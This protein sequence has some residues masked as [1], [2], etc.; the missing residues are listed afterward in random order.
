MGWKPT[1]S[2]IDGLKDML[3]N[4]LESNGCIEKERA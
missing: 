2:L 3:L 1:Y 4:S